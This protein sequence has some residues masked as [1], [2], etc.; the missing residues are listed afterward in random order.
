MATNN[1]NNEIELLNKLA[2]FWGKSEDNGSWNPVLLHLIDVAASAEAILL[3]E[4]ESTRRRMSEILGLEWELALPWIQFVIACHDLGK[5]CPGFQFQKGAPEHVK[6]M[7]LKIPIGVTWISH[8]FVSQIALCQFLIEKNWPTKLAQKIADAVGCHHGERATPSKLEDVEGNRKSFGEKDWNNFRR[9]ACL[10]LLE[11]FQPKATPTKE[12]LSGP[13]F[14]LLSGLASFA[15]WIG[16]NLKWFPFGT[17]QDVQNLNS[18]WE[19]SRKKAQQA[20]DSIGWEIRS[21]LSKKMSSFENVFDR[22]PRPLQDAIAKV[23][24]NI[25]KPSV[26]LVEAPMGEGKTEAAFYAHLELQRRLG[27]RGLYIALPTKATGN[28]MFKRTLEFLRLQGSDRP[29][30][31]QLLHGATLLNEEFQKICLTS[32][33]TSNEKMNEVSA[34]EWFTSKKR[35]LLSEYGV[36]TIDQALLGILPVR[37]QFVRL[38]GLANRVVIFDEIHAYDAYTGTLLVELIRWLIALGSSVILLSAT[39]PPNV[40]QKIADI[41]DAEF[42]LEDAPYPRLSVLQ[43]GIM[44]QTPFSTD[45]LRRR[46][47]K[48]EGISADLEQLKI[49]MEKK[50]ANGGMGLILVNTVQRAQKLYQLFPT[51]IPLEQN[52]IFFGKQLLDGTE[53]ILFHARFP[54]DKR[55]QREDYVLSVFG[56][57]GSRFGKKILI[58][59]QVVEQSLDLDFDCIVTDLAPIDLLLQRA[60]RL[61]RHERSQR[62]ISKPVF[63]VA[64]IGEEKP[65][66]FG[67]PFWWNSVY[68]EDILLRTWV[69]LSSKTEL[70]LPDE[71]DELVQNVYDEKGIIPEFLQERLDQA[72]LN[73]EGNACAQ[74]T[75][76][77]NA[78]IGSPS[79]ASWDDPARYIKNDEDDSGL[80]PSLIA[81]TRMGE[82]SIIVIPLFPHEILMSENCL[83]FIQSKSLYI[84]AISVSRKGI[85]KKLQSLGKPEKWQKSSLLRNCY[86]LKLCGMGRWL[87]DSSVRLDNE[88]GLIYESKEENETI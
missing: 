60:G 25:S 10:V 85:V 7:G 80:H 46:M 70:V 33:H 42:P 75:Q 62:P 50:L 5:I 79:D 73:G 22:K 58:A 13:D 67:D 82:P 59:T 68:R 77:Y 87:E 14:M 51:G 4:P 37:H 43:K 34:G 30:D 17:V 47:I 21:P 36:G 44:F 20:L 16:S 61:W 54:A 12:K 65:V 53:I 15:D 31:L 1:R 76:A 19:L 39:L 84:R 55:Q 3:R 35:A 38:W 57:E 69:L 78:T 86:A 29:L 26:I 32:I 66:G 88:L 81:Q 24:E 64:G 9:E 74:K 83:D 71:I 11:V 45:P 2:H 28:A 27:H 49:E 40:R 23:V 6:N 41:M 8:G 56:K 18:R 63:I 48:L 72:F 52:D